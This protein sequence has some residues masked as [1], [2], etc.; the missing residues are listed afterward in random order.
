M[1]L[2]PGRAYTIVVSKPEDRPTNAVRRCGVSWLDMGD[3]D[4]DQ[5]SDYAA[6]IMRNMLVSP[7]FAQAIQRVP[8]PGAEADVMGPY[9]P[10]SEYRS[11]AAFEGLGCPATG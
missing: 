8:E 1:V 4:G 6:L 5:R 7:D 3:G 2:G 11:R 9:F 10:Q